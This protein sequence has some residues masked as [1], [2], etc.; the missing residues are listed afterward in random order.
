MALTSLQAVNVRRYMGYSLSGNSTA[1]GFRELIY[2]DVS[3]MGLSLD[4]RLA[5]LSADEETVLVGYFLC[6]LQ[7]REQDIQ[8]ASRNLDTDTA[9]VWKRNANEIGDRTDMFRSLRIE[10]CN[11][12]GF[13]PGPTL[14]NSGRVVRG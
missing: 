4:Y 11:W 10:L 3:Y 9:A 14:M 6:N 7:A 13:K 12:L 2:S 8:N 5:N 1:A